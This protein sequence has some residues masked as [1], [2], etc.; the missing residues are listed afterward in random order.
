MR[1]I[2]M[3]NGR[4]LVCG[5]QRWQ[6]GESVTLFFFFFSGGD[7][8]DLA[9]TIKLDEINS[10]FPPF[11]LSPI[12]YLPLTSCKCIRSW[13][14]HLYSTEPIYFYPP[15]PVIDV[16]F[17]HVH[18]C[19]PQGW[20]KHSPTAMC[21]EYTA[22]THTHKCWAVNACGVLYIKSRCKTAKC[23]HT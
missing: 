6:G 15:C 5:I 18:P 17:Q 10:F 23:T 11:S 13:E 8:A 1:L 19:Y 4:F 20:I 16:S 7:K 2:D 3:D 22:H 21:R 14:T 9:W 12:F